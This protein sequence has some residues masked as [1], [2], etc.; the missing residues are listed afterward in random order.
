MP[1]AEPGDAATASRRITRDRIDEF[2][3][4][5]GDDNPLHTDAEYAGDGFFGEPIAHGMLAAGVISAALAALPGD[6]IYVSQDLNFEAPVYPGA[7]VTATAEVQEPTE[8]DRL[9]V[10]TTAETEDGVVVTGEA[11]VLSLHHD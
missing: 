1:V 6:I 2:A 11:V 8:G 4:V 3:A 7:T 10:E 9:R 5:T